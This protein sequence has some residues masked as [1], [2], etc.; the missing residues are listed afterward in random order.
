MKTI[1]LYSTSFHFIETDYWLRYL[2]F[3]NGF[4]GL[5]EATDEATDGTDDERIFKCMTCKTGV[6]LTQ[7]CMSCHRISNNFIY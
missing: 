5:E 7:L 4:V 2:I 3:M 6:E 1:Q